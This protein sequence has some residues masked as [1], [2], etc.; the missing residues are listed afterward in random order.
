MI[1][2]CMHLDLRSR[3]TVEGRTWCTDC[4]RRVSG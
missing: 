4:G 1:D 2:G 3:V